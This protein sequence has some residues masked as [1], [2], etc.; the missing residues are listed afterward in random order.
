MRVSRFG[1]TSSIA[2]QRRSSFPLRWL[3]GSAYLPST[4]LPEAFSQEATTPQKR[5]RHHYQTAGFNAI[6]T[7]R[8]WTEQHLRRAE[9]LTRLARDMGRTPAQMAEAWVLSQPGITSI[10]TGPS[11]PLQ[12]AE[13]AAAADLPLMDDEI[14]AIERIAPSPVTV[15]RPAYAPQGGR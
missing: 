7:K 5:C 9:E 6:Y 3:P 12:F 8:Y 2:V 14:E 11:D 10:M 4:R 15:E 1:I 13:Y